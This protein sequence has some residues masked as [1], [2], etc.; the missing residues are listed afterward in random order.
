MANPNQAVASPKPRAIR[1]VWSL[2]FLA[3]VALIALLGIARSAQALT[4]PVASTVAAATAGPPEEPEDEAEG[5]EG[6]DLE[7]EECEAGEEEA[8]EE[9]EE[10]ECEETS[11]PG[12][13]P[14]QCR[15]STAIATVS[16]DG[17]SN[18][19]RLAIRYTAASPA[20]VAIE[21][22]LRGSKGPLDMGIE[23][24]RFGAKGVFRD[25]ESM[26]AAQMTK[27]MAAKSFTVRLRPAGAPDY[28][29]R[30]LDSHLTARHA[31]HG[32]LTWSDPEQG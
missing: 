11:G 14:E 32:E 30:F 23:R 20:T 13:A 12:P 2:S 18:R 1:F 7:G 29:H 16:V 27:V 26:S 21:Y 4:V 8:E 10:E 24:A 6:E 19:V 25:T 9:G 3:T 17:A 15:T 22:W 28:C 5:E 31:S